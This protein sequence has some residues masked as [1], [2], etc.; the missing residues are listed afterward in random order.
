VSEKFFYYLTD[1]DGNVDGVL[2]VNVPLE[3]DMLFCGFR[4]KEVLESEH[5][6]M[7]AFGVKKYTHDAKA[8]PFFEDCLGGIR[9]VRGS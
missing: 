6:T 3:K 4:T 1:S 8:Y 9:D 7:I 2:T 5:D